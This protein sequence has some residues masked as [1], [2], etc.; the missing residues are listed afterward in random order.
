MYYGLIFVLLSLISVYC[1]YNPTTIYFKNFKVF[2]FFLLF[3]TSGLR[4]E[5]AVDWVNYKL[6][7]KNVDYIHDIFNQGFLDFFIKHPKE[8]LF[9][10]LNSLVKAFTNNVQVLFFLISLFTTTL[11]FKSINNYTQKKY[12]L[13]SILLYYVLIFFILDMSGIR[14]C[15]ALN[16][17]FY[18]F[19]FLNE[20]RLKRF[21]FFVFL[22]S[23]FHY[24]AIVFVFGVFLRKKVNLSIIT[25]LFLVG[26]GVFL[27]RI[28]W[29]VFSIQS[30]FSLFSDNN[31][32]LR[33]WKYTVSESIVS[34]ERPIFIMLFV[35]SIIY[36]FYLI[37]KRK[38]LNRN[39]DNFIFINLYSLF[40]LSTLFL[41]EISD[42]G[43]RFGLYFSMGL[44][45]SLPYI[46]DFFNNISKSFIVS[47]ILLYC[48]INIRP[49]VLEDRS[50]I[51][52][53]PYQNYLIY[54]LFDIKS[55]G[56]ERREIY[57]SDL[58]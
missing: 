44:I 13:F 5:T 36:L 56:S 18:S 46:L 27:F 32:Y 33:L 48:F 53:N 8:P 23:M 1:F 35:N 39:D 15:I 10:I 50:V 51:T 22:A 26:M 47:F 43:V 4:F 2:A 37:G 19:K 3:I 45:I 42:F 52:Y 30:L 16:I 55:T 25:T 12:F 14:Q 57:I 34:K 21:L 31:L 9:T 29:M 17:L 49:Y 11:L 24:S 20:K 28:R 40:I 7:F 54:E 41:W 6:Y 58:E 38:Y